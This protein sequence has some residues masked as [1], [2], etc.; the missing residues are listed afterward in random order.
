MDSNSSHIPVSPVAAAARAER[1]EMHRQ[2]AVYGS[3]DGSALAPQVLLVT[4]PDVAED[5][6]VELREQSPQQQQQQQQHTSM[7]RPAHLSLPPLRIASSPANSLGSSIPLS[8]NRTPSRLP[9][10]PPAVPGLGVHP[11]LITQQ[12]PTHGSGSKMPSAW[13]TPVRYPS[14][15]YEQ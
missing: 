7:R 8:R 5:D 12:Q 3:N 13:H 15:Y 11:L 2:L 6:L 10:M 9:P 4:S 14:M 1:E